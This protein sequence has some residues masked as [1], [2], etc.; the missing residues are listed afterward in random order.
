MVGYLE[1]GGLKERQRMWAEERYYIQRYDANAVF[2]SGK[3]YV[4]LC[5]CLSLT[6][7]SKT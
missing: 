1:G 7:V 2:M 3:G 4:T 5:K 6:N